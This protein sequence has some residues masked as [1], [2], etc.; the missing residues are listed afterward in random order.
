MFDETI[1]NWEILTKLI[2]QK[3]HH[4]SFWEFVEKLKKLKTTFNKVIDKRFRHIPKAL[5]R[6]PSIITLF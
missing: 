1:S 4:K 2:N 5:R 3:S 6:K